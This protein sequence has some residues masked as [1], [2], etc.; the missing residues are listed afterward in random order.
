MAQRRMFS[1]KIVCS[2]RFLK[3]PIDSQCLYFH[4]GLHA[5]DDGVVEAYTVMKSIGS[6][7]DNLRVLV[8]KG[9]IHILN[10]DLVA[11][12]LDWGEHNLIR[13]DR[14]V[15]SIY[16]SLLLQIV[17]EIE[18]ITPKPRADT[19]VIPRQNTTGRP[20]DTIGK[21]RIGKDS[22]DIINIYIPEKKERKLEIDE[23]MV[24]KLKQKG[25][26]E[27]LVNLEI[28]KFISYWTEPNQRGKQRW[29]GQKFFDVSRRLATWFGNIADRYS[30]NQTKHIN[31]DNLA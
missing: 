25:F 1:Q 12:I 30:K 11:F 18:L 9:F 27:E 6:S 19:G 10:E 20:L 26:P 7:E 29:E 3:M 5:D 15:D 24:E 4:L 22:I 16:K 21:D 17:P 13:A 14:K 2:A 8:S 23:S 31:L 28:K